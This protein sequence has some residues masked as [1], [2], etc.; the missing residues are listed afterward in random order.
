MKADPQAFLKEIGDLK[1]ALNEHAIVAITDPQGK[2]TYVNDKF[3]AISKYSREE[4]LGQD[5][6]IINSG[7]HPKEFFRDLWTTIAS[8][9]V[10]RG[11]IKNRAKDGTFYW[12]DTTIVPFLDEDGKPRQYIAIRTDITERKRAEEVLKKAALQEAA[13]QKN[14]IIKELAVIVGV[15]ALIVGLLACTNILQPVADEF[16]SKYKNHYD[17]VF[18]VL[19]VVI[20][21]FLIFSYRRWREIKSQ[22][23][24]QRVIERSLRTLH[25][26]LEMRVRQRTADLVKSDETQAKLAAII[27]GMKEACFALDKDWHFTFVNDRCE[28]LFRH[29]RGEMLGKSIWEVFSKLVGTPM[30]ANYRRAMAERTAVTFEAHSPIAQRWLEIRLFPSGDGLAAFLLDIDE[31]KHAEELKSRLVEIINSS[32]DAIVSKTLDGI[33]TSWN[34]GAE[35]MFG[36]STTEAV[37]KPMLIVFPPE[38]VNEEKEFLAKIARGENIKHFETERVRKD[39]KRF[40]VSVTLSPIMDN[41]GKIVGASKIARDIT[42]HRKLEEQFRQSQKMEAIGQM[43]GGVAHD[44]NNILAIIQMQSELLKCSG[45]LRAEQVEFTEEISLTV[46]RAAALTRQLLLFSRRE[47]F[48]PRDL[49]L[50][51]SITSTAK[52]LKRILGEDIK[53]QLKL[54]PEPTFIHADSSMMDQVLL[55]LCVNARDAMPNGGQLVIETSGVEFDEFAASQS[56]Q[57]RPGSFV[58]LSVSDSG[59]GIPPEILPKIFEPFFTTKGIGKGTGLGLATVFGIVQQHQ[60]WVNVYT[61]VSHGTTFRIYFP[62]LAKNSASS[63]QGALTALRGGDETILLV[64]DDPAL[65]A[66]MR[67][68]LSQF[69]YRILEAP[70]GVKALDVWKQN[71]NEISLVLT[72]LMMPDGMTGK[73]LAQQLLQQNPKLKVI[74][75]SGYS[76]EIIGKDFPLKE[77]VNFLTKPFQAAKLAQAIRNNLDS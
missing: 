22:M 63:S 20:L 54:T 24:Q 32:D 17:D 59:C 33:I 35:K 52:M 46:D 41:T 16:V 77:G 26:E 72:D 73:D 44:F 45:G 28:T 74:Y 71:S 61:E 5:H 68:A 13:R 43:A 31:R 38:R 9:K 49:D 15:G 1:A 65:R 48:Q 58:R 27:Q 39:G 50:S 30:E 53:V 47:V 67:K 37:G 18:G 6:R 64:E 55:N 10:W 66:S 75:M 7:F 70:T 56:P 69:G 14:R 12:V 76:T 3:C 60:G 40:F 8:G 4:L 29:R 34:H 11:E 62:R 57:M 51:A 19:G 21:G 2:I 23:G 36:Y 25:D 42:Q